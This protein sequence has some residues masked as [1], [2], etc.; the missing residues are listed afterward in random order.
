MFEELTG[1][2]CGRSLEG[3]EEEKQERRLRG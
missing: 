3:E 1:D 2:Q